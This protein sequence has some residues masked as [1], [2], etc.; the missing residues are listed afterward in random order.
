MFFDVHL[1]ERLKILGLSLDRRPNVVSQGK[2]LFVLVRRKPTML[3]L[4]KPVVDSC[5]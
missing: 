4:R 2:L 5:Q 3:S 1:T